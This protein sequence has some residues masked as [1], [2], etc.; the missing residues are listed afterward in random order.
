[1]QQSV[2]CTTKLK[3]IKWDYL[4]VNLFRSSYSNPQ[5]DKRLFIDL[6]VQYIHENY[7]L[8]TCCVHKLFWMSKQKNKQFVYTKCSELVVFLYWTCNSMNNLVILLVSWWKNKSFWQRFTCTSKIQVHMYYMLFLKIVTRSMHI[9]SSIT[10]KCDDWLCSNLTQDTN[11]MALQ[12]ND[13]IWFKTHIV[14][15]Y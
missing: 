9:V 11:K 13:L 10:S 8:K 5:Y 7:K 6:P 15:T 14:R 12:L 2:H 3:D 1:M 4:K